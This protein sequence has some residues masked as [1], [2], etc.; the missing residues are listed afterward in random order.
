MLLPLV[1]PVRE[2]SGS[3]SGGPQVLEKNKNFN[4]TE[5][6]NC[7]FRFKKFMYELKKDKIFGK[8]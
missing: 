3:F 5:K 2:E 7:N 1:P 6:L 4:Y 8:I